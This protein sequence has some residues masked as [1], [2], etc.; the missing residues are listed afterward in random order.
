MIVGSSAYVLYLAQIQYLTNALLYTAS[1]LIGLGAALLWTAQ[2]PSYLD[3]FD[4]HLTILT[5]NV[6]DSAVSSK[7]EGNT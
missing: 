7:I 4:K 3:Y 2:A 1:V 5:T 6:Y